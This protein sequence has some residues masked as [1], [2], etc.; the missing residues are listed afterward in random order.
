MTMMLGAIYMNTR[1]NLHVGQ[2]SLPL[3]SY[4][5]MYN[6]K[7]HE[8]S[9]VHPWTINHVEGGVAFQVLYQQRLTQHAW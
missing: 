1:L 4:T 6:T 2:N 8:H 7:L 9:T 3:Y 5:R